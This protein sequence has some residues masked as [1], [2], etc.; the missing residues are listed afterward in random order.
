MCIGCTIENYWKNAWKIL[1][2]ITIDVP[3]FVLENAT[4][5]AVKAEEYAMLY[6]VNKIRALRILFL[7][8]HLETEDTKGD[9]WKFSFEKLDELWNQMENDLKI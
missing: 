7:E 4:E 3:D 9:F 6:N 5:R 1:N 2:G 8:M